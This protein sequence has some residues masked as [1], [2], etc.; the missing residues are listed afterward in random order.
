MIFNKFL[1]YLISIFFIFFLSGVISAQERESC[2]LCG[3]F[4]DIYASTE[5]VI[6]YEDGTQKKTCSLACA[7]E[8][9]QK[10][11]KEVKQILVADFLSKEL[12]RPL[13]VLIDWSKI[14]YK[15][16]K[17]SIDKTHTILA[18]SKIYLYVSLCTK[19]IIKC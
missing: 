7:A 11:T 5:H 10:R 16:K 13:M 14:Q 15:Y 9:Y 3:M 17:N 6:I 1:S 19:C 12:A 2:Y 18:Q 8:L 4:L